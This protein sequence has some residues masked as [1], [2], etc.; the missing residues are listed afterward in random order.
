MVYI[1]MIMSIFKKQTNSNLLIISKLNQIISKQ[2]FLG[3]K[4]L[5]GRKLPHKIMLTPVNECHV[6]LGPTI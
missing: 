2:A 6:L 5:C 1:M 4:F 3:K